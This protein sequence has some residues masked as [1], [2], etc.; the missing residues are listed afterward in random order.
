M[1]EQGG[2]D[3]FSG[4]VASK[5]NEVADKLREV[6]INTLTPIEAMNTL[7]QLKKMLSD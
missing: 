6:D 3:L 4:I 2:F 5:E 7:F 1:A